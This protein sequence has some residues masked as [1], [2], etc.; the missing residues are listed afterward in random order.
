MGWGDDFL[1][2][3]THLAILCA[4]RRDRRKSPG[5]CARCSDCDF[6][7]RYR[8]LNLPAFA[9]CAPPRD[10]VRL[11]LGI[12]N[13]SGWAILSDY[14]SKWRR[15]AIRWSLGTSLKCHIAAIVEKNRQVCPHQSVAKIACDFRWRSN[16]PR[17][18]NKMPSVSPALPEFWIHYLIIISGKIPS[19]QG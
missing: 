17:S 14:F 18:V 4:D 19:P 13:Q 2:L 3:A 11:S 16:S 6:R 9:K 15:A 12:P 1:Q 10:F 7:R 5:T 8:R